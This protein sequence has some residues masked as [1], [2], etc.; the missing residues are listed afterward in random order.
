MPTATINV[1]IG[2]DAAINVRVAEDAA[3]NARVGDD[4]AIT[5]AT[6]TEASITVA[7][8]APGLQGPRGDI[9]PAG[10][11]SYLHT[12]ASPASTWT[13][14][15]NLGT[16]PAV[17]VRDTGGNE[18]LAGVTHASANQVLI[19]FVSAKTGTAFCSL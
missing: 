14:N 11:E 6:S 8:G 16:R 18:I 7:I 4:A 19:S 15:H 1:R 13:V 9:G 10:G 12:Q 17:E 5:V 2:D 3:I